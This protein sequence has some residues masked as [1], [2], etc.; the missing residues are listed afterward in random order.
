MKNVNRTNI[1][2]IITLG[3]IAIIFGIFKQSISLAI[4]SAFE[5][6]AIYIVPCAVLIIFAIIHF[7][8]SEKNNTKNEELNSLMDYILYFG[9]HIVI[10]CTIITLLRESFYQVLFPELS[11][12]NFSKVDIFSFLASVGGLTTY[13][14]S[15]LKPIFQDI[16]YNERTID[17]ERDKNT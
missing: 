10:I 8:Q 3:V 12:K 15:K 17:E 2:A 14:Y 9:T 7:F 6:S 11:C 4:K 1:A 16:I 13:I 5:D